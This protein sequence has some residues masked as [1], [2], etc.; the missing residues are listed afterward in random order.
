MAVN[1]DYYKPL[2]IEIIDTFET[3]VNCYERLEA[4][5]NDSIFN[6]SIVYNICN[7]FDKVRI[8]GRENA[9]NY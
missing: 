1:T 9:K 4:W 7:L 8:G 3:C 5:K 6:D 2:F